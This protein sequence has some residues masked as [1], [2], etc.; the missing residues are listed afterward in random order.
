MTGEG[1]V[2]IATSRQ[3]GNKPRRNRVKRRVIEALRRLG[4]HS[5]LDL[6]IVCQ[7]NAERAKF[8]DLVDDLERALKQLR[9][10]WESA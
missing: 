3:I 6:V 9:S 1:R 4:P 5:G 10:R 7:R 8:E 2:G